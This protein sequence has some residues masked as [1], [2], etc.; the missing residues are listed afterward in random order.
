[1]DFLTKCDLLNNFHKLKEA[2]LHLSIEMW[3]K[4]ACSMKHPISTKVCYSECN[5]IILVR[6]TKMDK[7]G[8]AR[9]YGDYY[10]AQSIAENRPENFASSEIRAIRLYYEY[11]E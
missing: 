1:M 3:A 9:A 4:G 11:G 8:K 2:C 6:H 7:N 10:C 5:Q